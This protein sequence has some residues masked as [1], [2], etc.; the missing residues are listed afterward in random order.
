MQLI[1]DIGGGSVLPVTS[2]SK[3]NEASDSFAVYTGR[4]GSPSGIFAL[5]AGEGYFVQMAS[6]VNYIVVGSH[7]PSLAISLDAPGGGSASGKN[8]L[9][10]PYNITA[11]NSLQLIQ[12]IGGGSVLPV[13]SV[14]KFNAATDTFAVYTGRMG[15]PSAIFALAPGEAYFVQMNTTVPYTPSHY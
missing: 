6:N 15:S 8:L 9:S 12:D 13:T 4:M 5:T 11:T 10:P 3:F 1:N 14:S 7:D 2:V